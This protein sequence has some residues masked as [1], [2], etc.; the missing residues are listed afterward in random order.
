[1]FGTMVTP[2]VPLLDFWLPQLS[3]KCRMPARMK[4]PASAAWVASEPAKALPSGS[5]WSKVSIS[6]LVVFEI[7]HDIDAELAVAENTHDLH[8]DIHARETV[9]LDVD[10]GLA[11]VAVVNRSDKVIQINAFFAEKKIARFCDGY[12]GQVFGSCSDRLSLRDI[13]F[14]A[15]IH[16]MRGDHENDEQHQR[17]I[18]K[19]GN[20]DFRD[21]GNASPRPAATCT[22][23]SYR[24]PAILRNCARSGSET[25][26]KNHPAVRRFP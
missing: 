25:R 21:G 14:Y 9:R 24:H 2:T 17:D 18:D 4:T 13:D 20:V 5:C 10:I 16:G 12:N 22:T 26:A 7:R 23:D 1:M 15:R 19:R 11:V 6:A 3:V 8:P